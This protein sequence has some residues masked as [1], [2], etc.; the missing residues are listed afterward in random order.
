[1]DTCSI[2]IPNFDVF[3]EGDTNGC[4]NKGAHFDKH[5][6]I[7]PDGKIVEWEFEFCPGCK[8]CNPEES[9]CF[10]YEFISKDKALKILKNAYNG[11]IPS[12]IL[13]IIS[14]LK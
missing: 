10:N 12:N 14:Q 7:L 3:F 11:S 4:L 5:I 13:D 1:M 2:I 6:N 8:D 9:E